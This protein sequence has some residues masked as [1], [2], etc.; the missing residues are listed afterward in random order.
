MDTFATR[1]FLPSRDPAK[2]FPAGSKYC[3]LD[4]IGADLPNRLTSPGGTGG[5]P[6]V[7]WLE[8]LIDETLAHR[9]R[10]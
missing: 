5:T 4:E 9:V 3:V 1:G 6:Y 7:T 10:A 2:A 8:R